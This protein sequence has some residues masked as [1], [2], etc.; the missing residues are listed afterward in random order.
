M[1][2]GRNPSAPS[3]STAFPWASRVT[4][5]QTSRLASSRASTETDQP[6]WR[7]RSR[8]ARQAM[9]PWRESTGW[10][11]APELAPKGAVSRGSG[12]MST[13]SWRPTWA[14]VTRSV[15]G[16]SSAGRSSAMPTVWTAALARAGSFSSSISYA[17][18][19]SGPTRFSSPSP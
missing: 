3:V 5:L 19:S 2:G 17:R 18:S 14:V 12:V 1:F 4:K 7:P 16:S 9:P 8:S 10:I 6:S 11:G 13:G 15:L